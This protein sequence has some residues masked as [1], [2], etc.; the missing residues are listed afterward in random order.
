VSIID[1]IISAEKFSDKFLSYIDG[2]GFITDKNKLDLLTKILELIWPK[3]MYSHF[4]QIKFCPNFRPKL[5]HKIDSRLFTTHLLLTKRDKR[6]GMNSRLFF[7]WNLARKSQA[8][9]FLWT[10]SLKCSVHNQKTEKILKK[11]V[12][13]REKNVKFSKRK[14]QKSFLFYFKK[15]LSENSFVFDFDFH[16]SLLVLKFTYEMLRN[17]FRETYIKLS[18]I[19]IVT[20]IHTHTNQHK[21]SSAST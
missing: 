12:S 11:C 21:Q 19:Q 9:Y 4:T 16:F 14:C 6:L 15:R 17:M 1:F 13:W 3:A 2:Q 7:T 8:K 18:L 20:Y 10:S 5:I